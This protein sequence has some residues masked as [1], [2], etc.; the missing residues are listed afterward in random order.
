MLRVKGVVLLI[1]WMLV[2]AGSV[3]AQICTR[4]YEPGPVFCGPCENAVFS[5]V[6][7]RGGAGWCQS[8]SRP[9][10]VITSTTD[11]EGEKAD[12]MSGEFPDP[13]GTVLGVL[14]LSD[15]QFDEIARADPA[16][17][18][19]LTWVLNEPGGKGAPFDL[20]IIEGVLLGAPSYARAWESRRTLVVDE[21]WESKQSSVDLERRTRVRGIGI[22]WEDVAGGMQLTLSSM[23]SD[24]DAEALDAGPIHS[25][26]LN[27][28]PTDQRFTATGDNR[29]ATVYRVER[30]R[31]DQP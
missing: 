8:C 14:S 11:N 31:V 12:C 1:G 27:L 16:I 28:A 3:E 22:P 24:A 4:V 17:A 30:L 2:P 6:A 25:V 26:R 20:R 18:E 21:T 7:W 5:D 29:Q 13:P 15:A 10:V 23:P 9:C 19:A